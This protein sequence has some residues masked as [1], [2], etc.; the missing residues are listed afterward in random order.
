MIEELVLVT[1][2]AR[3]KIQVVLTSL[4]QKGNSFYIRRITGQYQ[5]KMTEQPI[6]IIEKGKA[7]RSA[8]QQA[9]LGFKSKLSKYLDKGYKRLDSL[10]K[11]KFDDLTPDELNE[12][13]PTLKSDSNG[14]LKPS[15]AKS[16]KD[17]QLSVLEKPMWCSRKLN[18]VRMMV[19]IDGEDNLKTVSRGGK[20]YDV[21]AKLICEELHDFLEEHSDYII[22]GELYIHGRYLQEIS[23]MARLET[24]E[25][26]CEDL[27][28]WIYDIASDAMTFTQRLE[29]LKEMQELFEGSV[30]I[31]VID[32]V[33]TECWDDIQTL[34][35]K[36][37]EEGFEGLVARKPDKTYAYGKRNANMIKVKEYIDDEFEIIDYKDG[38]R[39]EDFSF[40]LQTKEG[41]VFS[42]SPIGTRE[43]KAKYMDDMDNIIGKKGT[44][45]YFDLSKDKLPQQTKFIA[46]RD[47]E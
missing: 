18:G 44:V 47:Y 40:I 22:D 9:E 10:T 13:V 43:L 4:D 31:K 21:P 26:R 24:W 17:C 39:P 37:V 27:E 16:S 29:I 7:K 6:I 30:R 1:R 25:K 2:N 5:N 35:D 36:W 23:G 3:D 42:A 32:H 19:K 34:H 12:L 33:L 20:T 14:N 8:L 46:V 11:K 38:L 41:G 15:L 45:R 28:Y